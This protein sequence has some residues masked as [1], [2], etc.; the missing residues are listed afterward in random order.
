MKDFSYWQEY[1]GASEG[2]GRSE[3]IW[4]QNPRDGRKGLFKFKKDIQ[5]TDHISEC[6]ACQIADLL[7]IPCA[8]FELGSYNGR[9]GSMSYN[10]IENPD[11]N[12]I[13]G[14]HFITSIYPNYDPERFKDMETKHMYSIEMIVRAIKEYV[15]YDDFIKML[16]FDY[17]IGNSDRHQSNWAIISENQEM[18]W[19][20]LYD[21]GS[22]LCSYISENQVKE[23][24]GNDT[25]RWKALVDTKSRSRI[26][27][28]VSERK[29]PTHLMVLNY[30]K[31]YYYE[32]FKDFSENILSQI[33]EN[34]IC[35][36]LDKYSSEELSGNKKELIT[37]Y[38]LSKCK[39][40][41][42][43]CLEKES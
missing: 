20:P 41:E 22:S 39:I 29:Q 11:Q 31:K 34:T 38:L 12:L 37:K 24:L 10:I 23:Y 15:S 28:T 35:D 18:R 21:N 1:D 27:C 19:S 6:I 5:T 32:I 13:E 33:K 4:L 9:D 30:I 40:L 7:N 2:S 36:C 26:R 17:L 16:M 25:L 43:L 3:K 8:R 42:N 14:I